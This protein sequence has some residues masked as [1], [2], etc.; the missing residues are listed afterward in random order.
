MAFSYV[1]PP[2]CNLQAC[3]PDEE[4]AKAGA[5]LKLA[6]DLMLES[7]SSEDAEAVKRDLAELNER[8]VEEARAAQLAEEQARGAKLA[9]QKVLAQVTENAVIAGV[10]FTYCWYL[11][12]K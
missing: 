3:V 2:N 4:R 7:G 1:F 6:V 10:L 8:L 5:T 12:Y 9:R 11:L